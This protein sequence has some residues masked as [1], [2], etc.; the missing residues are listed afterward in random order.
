MSPRKKI[1]SAEDLILKKPMKTFVVLTKMN[2][3]RKKI[4]VKKSP[5]RLNRGD[6]FS[7]ALE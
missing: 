5:G 1:T 6:S 7:R 2:T 3:S 4:Y